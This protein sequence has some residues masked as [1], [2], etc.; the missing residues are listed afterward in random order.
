MRGKLRSWRK[1]R[2]QKSGKTNR[3]K[4]TD[5]CNGMRSQTRDYQKMKEYDERHIAAFLNNYRMVDVI[6][7]AGISKTKA[8]KLRND[9]DF[10]KVIRERKEAILK[11]AVNKMTATLTGD[12]ETLQKI[13]DDPE[14]SPQVKINALQVKWNQMRE[15]ITT[16]DIIKRLEALENASEPF[17]GV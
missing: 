4:R 2:L 13:I 16:T 17:Q 5:V 12:V 10:M 11:A 1:M 6:R 15:W 3:S 9:P 14:T 7:E 8:Y